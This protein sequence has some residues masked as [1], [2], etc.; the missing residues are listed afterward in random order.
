MRDYIGETCV[1]IGKNMKVGICVVVAAALSFGATTARAL[2][3]AACENH[4]VAACTEI[5][6]SWLSTPRQKAGGY[7]NRGFIYMDQGRCDLALPD[8]AQ[9]ITIDRYNSPAYSNQGNC[10]YESKRY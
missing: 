4:D 9:A 8:L 3:I 10:Y 2:P 7:N 5:I 6:N 1:W